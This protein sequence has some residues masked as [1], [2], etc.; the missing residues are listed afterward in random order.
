M[1][2]SA[3][4]ADDGENR[5]SSDSESDDEEVSRKGKGKEKQGSRKGKEKKGSRLLGSD[6]RALAG[7]VREIMR[8][9]NVAKVTR[10]KTK[11]K[12]CRFT[13]LDRAKKIQQAKMTKN[14]DLAYKVRLFPLSDYPH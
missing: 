11:R 9:M 2:I 8:E 7:L 13:A 12:V 5:D 4:S 3:D 10:S 1:S 6:Q 14:D